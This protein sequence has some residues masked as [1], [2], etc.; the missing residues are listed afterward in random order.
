MSRTLTSWV[1]RDPAVRDEVE[2]RA[3][4]ARAE[5]APTT[6]VKNT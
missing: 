4:A 1:N 5:Q 3:S 2:A 6:V